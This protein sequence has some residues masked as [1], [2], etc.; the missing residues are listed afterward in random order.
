MLGLW[1]GRGAR[2][3]RLLLPLWGSLQL[4]M[5]IFLVSDRYRMATWPL[6]CIG[7]ALS[8]PFLRELGAELKSRRLTRWVLGLPL[9]VCLLVAAWWPLHWRTRMDES[10]C[11]YAEANVAYMDKD[12]VVAERR[13]RE[14]LEVWPR[15]MGAHYWLAH[16][17][18]LDKNYRAALAHMDVV[19]EQFP[20]HFPSLRSYAGW[21]EREGLIDDAIQAYKRAYAVPG[22]RTA[23]GAKLVV[24]LLRAGRESEARALLESDPRL[25]GQRRVKAALEKRRRPSE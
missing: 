16:L 6:L 20:D 1:R 5:F 18:A 8:I 10:L 3:A 17:S 25:A 11:R 2:Q 15:D 7:A 4:P 19:L 21:A 24:A 13:Y 12:Y 23:T 14:V 22:D 9:L